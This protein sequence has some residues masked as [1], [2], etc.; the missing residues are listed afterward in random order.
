MPDERI[1][2]TTEHHPL[3]TSGGTVTTDPPLRS[4][5]DIELQSLARLP[6]SMRRAYAWLGLLT[7]LSVVSLGLLAGFTISLRQEN[8]QLQQ[9]LA[10][11]NAYKAQID[12]VNTL[13]T[14]I[15]TLEAQSAGINQNIGVIRQQVPK[16]LPTQLKNIQ[17]NIASMQ[18]NLQRVESN[19]VTRQQMEQRIQQALQTLNNPTTPSVRVIPTTPKPPSV[20]R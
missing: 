14:R 10:S 12:Q 11:L 4:S 3:Y 20:K 8:K 16:D 2:N 5:E 15:T 7:G 9:Q 6:Y 13:E 17:G 19:T 1:G 18:S